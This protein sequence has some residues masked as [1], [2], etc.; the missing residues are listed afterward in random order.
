MT[1]AVLQT[2]GPRLVRPIPVHVVILA[3]GRGSRLGAAGDDRPKW[4]LPVGGRTIADRQLEGIRQAGDA[5][6]STHVVVGHAASEIEELLAARDDRVAT[7][8]NREF[9]ER[10]NWWSVLRALRNLPGNEP[11]V[12]LNSDLMIDPG[13]QA[14]FLRTA[15]EGT[16]GGLLA[17]DRQRRLT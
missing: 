5:V 15:A 4:L 10:N 3:A 13:Q 14:E 12:I 7:I 8:H 16:P 9:V 6:A 11:V 2:R 1:D 17:V